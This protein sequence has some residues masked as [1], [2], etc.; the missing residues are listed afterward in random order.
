MRSTRP[1]TPSAGASRA[2]PA[3]TTPPACR[4]A[5]ASAFARAGGAPTSALEPAVSPR[6][7]RH[8]S[9]PAALSSRS[10]STR[11]FLEP[12]AVPGLEVL[13][14]DI[15]TQP[16]PQGEFDLVHARLLFS[17]CGLAVLHTTDHGGCLN[18]PREEAV[19]WDATRPTAPVRR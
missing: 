10:T 17:G 4:S 11:A 19:A 13:R 15:T 5:S 12:L 2:S 16:L 8:P 14:A 9:R 6:S 18:R 7:L 3:S 1:G